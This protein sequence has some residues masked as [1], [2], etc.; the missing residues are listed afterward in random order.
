M[1]MAKQRRNA[2]ARNYAFL[3]AL[4]GPKIICYFANEGGLLCMQGYRLRSFA[5]GVSCFRGVAIGKTS[6][7][8]VARGSKSESSFTAHQGCA[9]LDP[10][11]SRIDSYK[12]GRVL[13]VEGGYNLLLC[14][15]TET[16]EPLGAT[17]AKPIPLPGVEP[18]RSQNIYYFVPRR[19][20]GRLVPGTSV[21][22][23]PSSWT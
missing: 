15:A 14:F 21:R 4:R 20:I 16:G 11:S 18:P 12:A 22:V 17:D 9:R 1:K 3:F 7:A 23:L 5:P 19:R 10:A 13:I 8:T 6:R 2:V